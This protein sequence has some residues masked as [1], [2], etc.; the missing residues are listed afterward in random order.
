MDQMNN[1][2]KRAG[3]LWLAVM[4]MVLGVLG[5][6]FTGVLWHSWRLAEETRSWAATP[7]KI[8][9]SQVVSEQATPHSS[10][11]YRPVVRY[12]YQFGGTVFHTSR[13]RR[14][15][16][17]KSYREDAEALR[18]EYTPGQ[19]LT[20]WVNP[21]D[22]S[23][24]VLQHDTRAPLYSIWFPLLFV[25]GGLRMAWGALRKKK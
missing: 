15:E 22:P 2:S 18:E 21:A 6:L 23:Y 5:T 1:S 13:V 14:S 19:A 3:S 17:P 25:V 16:G 10:V 12:E 24:A 11:K 20:C 7:A 4:G 9:S 8:L